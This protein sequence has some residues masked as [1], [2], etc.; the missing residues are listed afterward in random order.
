MKH[1]VREILLGSRVIHFSTPPQLL[2]TNGV[3][4]PAQKMKRPKPGPANEFT[5]NP[6][7]L[8]PQLFE[9]QH[10]R[11]VSLYATNHEPRRFLD[12]L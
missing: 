2:A 12:V 8:E 9:R 10:S 11:I 3:L 6:L 5:A 1:P 7:R 4:S